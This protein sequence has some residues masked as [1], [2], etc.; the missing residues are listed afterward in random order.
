L[1]SAQTTAPPQRARAADGIK[2]P[3]RGV[4]VDPTPA[5]TPATP[6]GSYYALVIGNNN[7]KF[8]NHL[9]TAVSDA[10]AVAKMLRE[11]YGFDAKV[12][13]DATRE[14]VITALS[15]YRHTLLPTSNLLI[16]YAGHGYHDREVDEAYWIPVDATLDNPANWISANDITK[17]IRAIQ[18]KHILIISDSCYSGALMRD[19]SP[20]IK[21]EENSAYVAKMLASKSRHLMSS[22]GDEP[23]ADG[24]GGAGHS[25]FAN[26]LLESLSTMEEKEFSAGDLFQRYV[27]RG[28]AGRSSQLP[29]YGPIRNSGDEH[30]DFVFYRFKD[31]KAPAATTKSDQLPHIIGGDPQPDAAPE[32]SYLAPSP[33]GSEATASSP[34]T[35]GEYIYAMPSR[36]TAQT[37]SDGIVLLS[38]VYGTN[39]RCVVTLWPT[40]SAGASLLADADSIFQDVYK[41]YELRNQTVRGT[42]MPHSIVRGT[43]GQGWDYVVIRR[44][45]APRGSPES[46]LGFVFVAKLNNRLAVISGVSR[47]PLVSSCMGELVYNAWPRFF[48]SLS[49]KNWPP[50]DQGSA[51]QQKVAGVW[52][53][54]T[55]TAADQ[56]AFA[57]NGRYGGAAAAQQYN[58]INSTEVLRTTQAYFG[59]GAYTLRGNTITLTPDDRKNQPETGFIRVEEESKDEGRSW[60]ESLYLLRIS[61]IDGKDYE[62][63][64]FKK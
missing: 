14:Q 16:Y 15:G 45:V 30:G 41:T 29:D 62:V 55:A 64:Y 57:A 13:Q 53:A 51:M 46:R 37:Y 47:D 25:I 50:T 59:N 21:P 52:T 34:A 63:R 33:A 38:P 42:P 20:T 43:S 18:S 26:A 32:T 31:S 35:L 10:Q 49:F 17:A 39:E 1:L 23:V 36:W 2:G 24:G 48:Y 54:A 7:Y 6:R 3:Q 5:S 12:L 9:Q 44:G 60:V 19:I 4:T 8:V 22:G 40:R 11:S 27:K 28:V 56:M 58:R 61:A